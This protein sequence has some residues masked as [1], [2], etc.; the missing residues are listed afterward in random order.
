MFR[1]LR[2]NMATKACVFEDIPQEY[3]GLGGRAQGVW[4]LLLGVKDDETGKLSERLYTINDMGD[5]MENA[6]QNMSES[7]LWDLYEAGIIGEPTDKMVPYAES[8]APADPDDPEHMQ[9][10][11]V[12][13]VCKPIRDCTIDELMAAVNILTGLADSVGGN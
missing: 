7:T 5:M 13:Y 10:D 6:T 8:E 3:A 2:V 4:Y 12:W 1:F 11:G 9:I